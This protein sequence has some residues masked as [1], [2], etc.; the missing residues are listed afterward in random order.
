MR[1]CACTHTHGSHGR[2]W[3]KMLVSRLYIGATRS[4]STCPVVIYSYAH[5]KNNMYFLIAYTYGLFSIIAGV[6]EHSLVVGNA[7]AERGN[8]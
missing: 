3:W 4:S 7:E 6:T 2:I 8:V 5:Y 1:M